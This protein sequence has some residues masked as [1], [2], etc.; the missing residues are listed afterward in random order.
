LK[1]ERTELENCVDIVR[2]LAMAN[3]QTQF[4]LRHHDRVLLETKSYEEPLL[5]AARKRLSDLLGKEFSTNSIAIDKNSETLRVWGFAGLPTYN[6][7]SNSLQYLFV[8]RRP[9]R[10]KLLLGVIR[11]AYQDYLARDRHPAVVLFLDLPSHM[12]DVNVHPAKAEVRFRDSAR[13]RSL[14]IA[15]LKA[16]LEEGGSRS[17][18]TIATAALQAFAPS[19][20]AARIQNSSPQKSDFSR[21]G[22]DNVSTLYG[23]TFPI[24]AANTGKASLLT[25]IQPPALQSQ[26]ASNFTSQTAEEQ[27]NQASAEEFPLGI[28]RC[29]LHE[30]YIISQTA[31]GLVIIDQHAAHERIVYEQMKLSVLEKNLASQRILLPEVVEL[32]EEES[33][34][35]VEHKDALLALGLDIERL[36]LRSIAVNGTPVLLGDCDISKLVRDVASDLVERETAS[37]LQETILEICATM[38]CHSS[39]RAGKRLTLEEMNM[40]LR[41]MERTPFS[42]QCNHGRPTY[43]SLSLFDIEKLFGRRE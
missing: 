1:S 24:A 39:V 29:Q 12:V 32:T 34:C 35:M 27:K 18:S 17:S 4:S 33:A 43:I 5:D 10:D 22:L 40:L 21:Y 15:A 42:G 6:R 31:L 11:A 8:N 23:Q 13:V 38:A 16:A 20:S 9:V 25:E 36:G 14:L 7:N 26:S 3:P 2:R 41:K 28:A 19:Y 30:T 37:S